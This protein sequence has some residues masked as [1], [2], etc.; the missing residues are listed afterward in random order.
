MTGKT[1]TK[2]PQPRRPSIEE[3]DAFASSGPG[4]DT[5]PTLADIRRKAE[6]DRPAPAPA[7]APAKGNTKRVVA[8]VP[9]DLHR[10]FKIACTLAG[11]D[12]GPELV[13]FIER[14]TAELEGKG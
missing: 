2:A 9:A 10:R 14:R 1:F 7:P 4:H 12:M 13:A 8:D 11:L 3:M 5:A 6:S